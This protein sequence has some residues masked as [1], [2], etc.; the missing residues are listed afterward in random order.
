MV[1]LASLLDQYNQLVTQTSSTDVRT[2]LALSRLRQ[3]II[4]LAANLNQEVELPSPVTPAWKKLI[5]WS[6]SIHSRIDKDGHNSV[7]QTG[8]S[9]AFAIQDMSV[10]APVMFES[11][12]NIFDSEQPYRLTF[13]DKQC[14]IK[15]IVLTDNFIL[16]VQEGR[17]EVKLALHHNQMD[18]V[19]VK[20][21]TGALVLNEE[22]KPDHHLVNRISYVLRHG[23]VQ[24]GNQ[25]I[26][27]QLYTMNRL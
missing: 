21:I 19:V 23:I 2:H 22:F 17:V 4:T 20:V 16:L 26:P 7:E 12:N 6:Q 5:A 18:F 9:L 13:S 24:I 10:P 8:T 3:D 25:T 11:L 15:V 14:T 27:R 1:D